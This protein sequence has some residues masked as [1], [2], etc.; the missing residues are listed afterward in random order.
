MIGVIANPEDYP[1]VAEFFELF[2]TPWEICN[3]ERRYDVLLC[4]RECEIP[5]I[6]KLA[7]I[8]SGRRKNTPGLDGTVAYTG[9]RTVSHRGRHIPIYGPSLFFRKDSSSTKSPEDCDGGIAHATEWGDSSRVYI[10][11][12][13]FDEVRL[14][15]TKGQPEE[16]ASIPSLERHIAL[17]RDVI[18]DAGIPLVEILPVPDG[19]NFIACLTH[20]V[21]HPSIGKH[22]FDHTMFGFLYRAVFGSVS[23]VFRGRL[24]VGGL[25]R[26]W[27]AA[28][29]L[30]LVYLGLSKDFWCDLERYVELEKGVGSS[31]FVIPFKDRPGR[32]SGGLAPKRRAARYGAV[33]IACKLRQLMSRGCEVGLHGIDAWWNLD[34]CCVEIEEIRRVTGAS[35]V[36][37][38]MHW[39]Y[40]DDR[41][42]EILERAG[43][44]YDSS[45]G[46][47]QTVGYRAGTTQVYK[48]LQTRY[49]LE[50]PLHIM[51]TALFYPSHLDLS[52][53]QAADRVAGILNNTSEVGGC[54]TVNWHD[55]S[56]APERLWGAFYADLVHELENRGAWFGTAAQAVSWF[57]KRRSAVFE[58]VRWES[59]AVRAKIA[60]GIGD[61]LPGLQ[62]R[63]Y[64][65]KPPHSTISI[66]PAR[67]ANVDSSDLGH[68]IDM[69]GPPLIC[70]GQKE[71]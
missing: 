26:N 1:V 45:N 35:H 68:S 60:V 14:L 42:P 22:R 69:Y 7:V 28:L 43:V 62:L 65:G 15:L 4:S 71:T 2:K 70:S 17:L 44:D 23:R 61:D 33:E 18:I 37:V 11:Y 8:Y 39:L 56:I 19:Y 50:L 32:G 30:P 20:D 3:F 63:V 34:N 36:G 13:L 31:F 46:Y 9:T 58:D 66:H 29:R 57:R 10:G 16:Q 48:P 64:S 41:S 6:A 38:R 27:L 55:R 40:F 52:F 21:D 12:D 59:G 47:N 54:V 67:P 53:T 24:G 5:A 51:D 25:L 49:L